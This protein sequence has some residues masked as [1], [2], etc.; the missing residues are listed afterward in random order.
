[1]ALED[2]QGPLVGGGLSGSECPDAERLAEYVDG[3]LGVA[4]RADVEAH[5][6]GCADCRAVVAE[7]TAFVLTD[8]AATRSATIGR[9]VPFRKRQWVR[10]VAAGLA[11]A[12]AIA[13][14]V[15]VERSQSDSSALH[16]LVAA[17]A[18]EPTRPVEGRLTGGFKYAPPP[19]RMR[20][21][22]DREVSH[23]IR[24][25]A[26]NIEKLA[27]TEYTPENEAALGVAYLALGDFDKAVPALE[28]AVELE[29]GNPR[30]QSDLSAAYLAR[31]QGPDDGARA[32]SAAR[33]ATA[34]PSSPPEAYFNLALAYERMGSAQD[35]ARAW[36]EYV[37]RDSES[38]WAE[39][40]KGRLSR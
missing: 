22:R 3:V 18:N 5:L 28:R 32:L 40:A 30:F 33:A 16:E 20:G 31:A 2:R 1:M 15:Q 27:A 34:V 7:T 8:Q 38:P 35:A 21:P 10:G 6:A 14:V 25:A 13:I 11:A 26:A 24:I 37:K 9:V 23:D 36:A 12:A 17:V 39:E 19:S 4:E 29:P